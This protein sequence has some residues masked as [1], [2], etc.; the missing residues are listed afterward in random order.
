ML[1]VVKAFNRLR[2]MSQ[3]HVLYN[4][5]NRPSALWSSALSD[6]FVFHLWRIHTIYVRPPNHHERFDMFNVHT[7][8]KWDNKSRHWAVLMRFALSLLYP[9]FNFV[10]WNVSNCLKSS[11]LRCSSVIIRGID[12]HGFLLYSPGNKHRRPRRTLLYLTRRIASTDRIWY[13]V[14]VCGKDV[15]V[16]L[17]ADVFVFCLFSFF[18]FWWTNSVLGSGLNPGQV[19]A[20]K[21]KYANGF[22]YSPGMREWDAFEIHVCLDCF[23]YY[24]FS[25]FFTFY[26]PIFW[27]ERNTEFFHH[28][29]PKK[30]DPAKM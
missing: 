8:A 25:F 13:P 23:Y 2:V 17:V 1:S 6:L 16:K 29:S 19:Q 30:R 21:I 26:G 18:F 27:N 24:F 11:V 9:L 15:L 10:H 4:L 14:L 20:S 7:F 3:C 22:L 12:W 28:E 5:D